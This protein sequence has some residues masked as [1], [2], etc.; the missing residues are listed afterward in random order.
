MHKQISKEKRSK[1]LQKNWFKT[2]FKYSEAVLFS[3]ASQPY[4][5]CNNCLFIGIFIHLS[6]SIYLSVKFQI[7]KPR[8]TASFCPKHKYLFVG[9]PWS[10]GWFNFLT[11]ALQVKKTITMLCLLS[12]I[13]RK[14]TFR[15]FLKD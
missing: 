10:P 14:I 7:Q 15:H 6:I 4:T 9:Q 12:F 11:F 8:K 2:Q 5:F 13:P 3:S 1:K